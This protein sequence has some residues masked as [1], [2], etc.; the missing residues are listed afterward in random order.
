MAGNTTRG[1]D[2]AIT[3]IAIC[4][5][6]EAKNEKLMHF[7]TIIR[8]YFLVLQ[9]EIS[10]C[11]LVN[12]ISM[13]KLIITIVVIASSSGSVAHGNEQNQDS[14]FSISGYAETYYSYDF[15]N[16]NKSKKLPFIYSY[17]KNNEVSVNLAFLKGSY[18]SDSARAN[19]AIAGGSYM[20]ANYASEPGVL[21]N[22]YESNIGLKLSKN[23]N[24]WFDA[25]VFS[26][27][28][29]FE[30]AIGKDNWTLT[31]SIG[32]DSAPY[33]ETGAKVSYTSENDVWFVSAL[34]LNGWQRIRRVQG[35]SSPSFGTQITYKPSAKVTLNSS[36]FIGNDK[37]DSVKKMR[38]F[39]NFY[40]IFLLN[41]KLSAAFG[42]DIGAEQKSKG[43][44]SYNSWIN[45]T[46]IFKYM[47]TAKTA[48]A[49]RAEYY[50]D[51][52]G[53]IIATDTP[54]GFKTWGFSTNFD[55]SIANNIV[56][57]A[58]IKT[59]NSKDNIFTK[60]NHM[61]NSNVT[62]TSA[63]AVSF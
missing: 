34:V 24:L 3:G 43:S 54:N 35:N 41:D 33:F 12:K 25:G 30:S 32:A 51:K 63:L 60:N 6:K 58:E 23:N 53:V 9:Y 45:P 47:P 20:S 36:T 44:S 40:G 27:H 8:A 7:P 56:W 21:N 46:L 48:I 13:K 17:N 10:I 15:N 28:L 1:E 62:M 55:Y 4:L 16:P 49:V 22:I 39:H 50:E 61:V 29:G 38:Y 2:V 42:F 5:S 14:A 18:N 59:L 26:S 19:L 52:N 31:R 57:R 37:P 11:S